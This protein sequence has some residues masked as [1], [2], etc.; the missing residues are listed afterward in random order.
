MKNFL[1]FQI[2]KKKLELH[3]NSDIIR[4]RIDYL[5]KKVK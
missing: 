1:E 2:K 3:L 4:T 5:S